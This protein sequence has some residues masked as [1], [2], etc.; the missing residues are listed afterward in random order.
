MVSM[1]EES[2]TGGVTFNIPSGAKPHYLEL[3]AD[4]GRF[5][6]KYLP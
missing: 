5:S 2:K 4:D 6:R 3:K 1:R